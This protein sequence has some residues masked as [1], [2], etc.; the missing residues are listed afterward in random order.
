MSD[1]RDDHDG[2]NRY[3]WKKPSLAI[4]VSDGHKTA[5]PWYVGP[6]VAFDLRE[7]GLDFDDLGLDAPPGIHVWEG[8]TKGGQRTYE[9]DYEDTYLDG[10]FRDL[11][12]DEWQ[13][14]REGRCPWND[15]EWLRS[16]AKP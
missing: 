14:V 3:D 10:E 5:V 7:H 6:H 12:D 1:E 13:A 2:W 15:D 16:G 8:V 4:V 11:T 9:G